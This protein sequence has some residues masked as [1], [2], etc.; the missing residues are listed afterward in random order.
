VGT[1]G[2][3]WL[4][5]VAVPLAFT[6]MA[7]RRLPDPLAATAFTG[8]LVL[9]TAAA[10][11]GHQP[12]HLARAAIFAAALACFYLLLWLI[13]PG[14]MGLGT[15]RSLPVSALCSAGST[16]RRLSSAPFAGFAMAAVYGGVLL[17]V[18]GQPGPA[19]C[20]SGLYPSWR[21]RGFRH[22]TRTKTAARAGS[23]GPRSCRVGQV[24]RGHGCGSWQRD[25]G[26]ERGRL[27]VKPGR[28]RGAL[29]GDAGR[30]VR[31]ERAGRLAGA[32]NS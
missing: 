31:E 28:I 32:Q 6:G 14:E 17:T 24:L 11:A 1:G 29:A 21:A 18:H 25:P 22:L 15:R 10:L 23:C 5:L 12:A 9:L 3:A 13:R 8:T 16:G 2:T 27:R 7:V 26:K 20:R 19:I 30:S 4:I